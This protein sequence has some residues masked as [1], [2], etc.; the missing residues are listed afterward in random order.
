MGLGLGLGL[1]LE[2]PRRAG[3]VPP[4]KGCLVKLRVRVVVRHDR[5]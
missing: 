2:T 4:V 5:S 1:G 3:Y